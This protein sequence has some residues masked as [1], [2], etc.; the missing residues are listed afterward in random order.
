MSA[1]SRISWTN[2]SVLKFAGEFDPISLIEEKA[3]QLVL[4]A[5]DGGWSGPPYNPIAIADLLKIPVEASVVS[6]AKGYNLSWRASGGIF[7]AAL[8]RLTFFPQ[9]KRIMEYVAHWFRTKHLNF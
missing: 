4:Q 5:R 3:R 7:S 8:P 6:R 1:S 2:K 9:T